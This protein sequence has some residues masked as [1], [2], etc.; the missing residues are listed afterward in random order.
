MGVDRR[1]V[2][3]IELVSSRTGQGPVPVASRGNHY[4]S[5]LFGSSSTQTFYSK[6]LALTDIT[7]LTLLYGNSYGTSAGPQGDGPG[8]LAVN[9]SVIVGGT[10]YRARATAFSRNATINPGAVLRTEPISVFIPKGTYF[11][12]AT[13]VSGNFP[14]G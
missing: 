11:F 10:V 6:H 9:A 13:Y 7:S 5:G 12:V 1:I 8:D 3:P 14:V 2:G 4:Y